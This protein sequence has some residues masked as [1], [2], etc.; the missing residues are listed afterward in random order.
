MKIGIIINGE[1]LF[2]DAMIFEIT[3]NR[4]DNA[5]VVVEVYTEDYYNSL[6][7]PPA[8]K[9]IKHEVPGL[10]KPSSKGITVEDGESP[11]TTFPLVDVKDNLLF[12]SR[13]ENNLKIFETEPADGYEATEKVIETPAISWNNDNYY[14]TIE[15]LIKTLVKTEKEIIGENFFFILEAPMVIIKD[16]KEGYVKE[17]VKIFEKK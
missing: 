8:D 9:D 2:L 12:I 17:K 11:P 3:N 13:V 15:N 16:S 14:E 4:Y 10:R 7:V 1:E 5:D 6:I